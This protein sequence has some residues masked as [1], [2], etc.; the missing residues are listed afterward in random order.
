MFDFLAICR[1]LLR[2]WDV[3]FLHRVTSIK[4]DGRKRGSECGSGKIL[5]FYEVTLKAMR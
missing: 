1:F 4:G 3:M 2:D 5:D